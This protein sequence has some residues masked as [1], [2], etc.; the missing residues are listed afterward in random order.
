MRQAAPPA[1]RPVVMQQPPVVPQ[2]TKPAIPQSPPVIR[3]AIHCPACGSLRVTYP[4]MTRKF[5]LPTIA[6][7]LGII[8]RLIHHEA[9][10]DKCHHV[11]NLTQPKAAPSPSEPAHPPAQRADSL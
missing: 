5:I 4:Q 7:N 3:Q 2:A 11:W 1:S 9:Y 8:F 10:C 6:L